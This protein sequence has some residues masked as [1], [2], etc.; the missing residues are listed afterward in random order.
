[1]ENDYI[2]DESRW[3]VG[4][5]KPFSSITRNIQEEETYLRTVIIP[6]FSPIINA[7]I[8]STILDR[9]HEIVMCS[10]QSAQSVGLENWQSA[11][12]LSYKLYAD[13]ALLK[14][15]FKK[16]YNEKTAKLIHDYAHQVFRIQQYVFKYAQSVSFIDCLPYKKE[17]N[18]YLVTFSPIFDR[19]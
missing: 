7:P 12:G 4:K 9:K 19:N 17:F 10:N 2:L 8:Y 14:N 15:H 1:M 16:Y 11:L 5:E 6:F 13:I 18:S 3:L